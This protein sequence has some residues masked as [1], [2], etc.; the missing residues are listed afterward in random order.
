MK[1]KIFRKT[2]SFAAA[3][4][5]I[6]KEKKGRQAKF[7]LNF[8]QYNFLIGKKTKEPLKNPSRNNYI[9][10][11]VKK[12]VSVTT[13]KRAF[14]WNTGE[15]GLFFS[16]ENYN[17]VSGRRNPVKSKSARTVSYISEIIGK[18]KKKFDRRRSTRNKLI[19][20]SRASS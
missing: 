12:K 18:K 7:Q 9:L 17:P 10:Y 1:N 20:K 11:N 16:N 19:V 6:I 13:Y 14:V 4:I 5:S 8:S 3:M 2:S 15:K